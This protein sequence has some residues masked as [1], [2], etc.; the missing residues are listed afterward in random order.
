MSNRD[1]YER[2]LDTWLRS[3]RVDHEWAR[4][5]VRIRALRLEAEGKP[6]LELVVDNKPARYGIRD[7]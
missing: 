7:V 6:H 5:S 1:A 2:E 4:N 3:R